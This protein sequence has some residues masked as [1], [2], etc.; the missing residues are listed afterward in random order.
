[1]REGDSWDLS[2]Q[3]HLQQTL[4]PTPLPS[5]RYLWQ[6]ILLIEAG[7]FTSEGQISTGLPPP[8]SPAPAT[9]VAP[10]TAMVAV[11]ALAPPG[12]ANGFATAADSVREAGGFIC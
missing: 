2:Q 12:G 9:L 4:P 5:H 1:M 10:M 8:S 7:N 6:P 3:R 11:E